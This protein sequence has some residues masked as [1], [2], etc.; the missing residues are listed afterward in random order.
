MAQAY[1]DTVHADVYAF[2]GRRLRELRTA[3][4]LT[5]AEVARTINVSPQQYQKYED[6]QSKCNLTYLIALA[7]FYGVHVNSILP[8]DQPD[9]NTAD[10][11]SDLPKEA[12]MLARLVSSFVRLTDTDEKLRLVQLVEA[13]VSAHEK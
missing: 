12:D 9:R 13:I 7:D 2:L 11:S 10:T 8:V 1:S 6:A 5:Q 3:R 4:G